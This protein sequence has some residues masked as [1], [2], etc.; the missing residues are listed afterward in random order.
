MEQQL[1][2]LFPLNVVL[3][4]RTPL[5][6]HIF[7]DRYKEMMADIIETKSEFGVVLAGEKGVVNT[8]CTAIVDKV[9]NKYEDG[10]MDILAVGRRRFEILLLNADK[11]YLRGA[12][13]F[14]DDDAFEPTP[15][16]LKDRVL[17]GYGDLCKI[18]PPEDEVSPEMTDP[19]LSFQ[20]AQILP[21][22]NFRQTLLATRSEAERMK[23][24]ADFLPTFNLR[25][26][27][28]AHVKSVAPQNGHGKRSP[29]L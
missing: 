3:F 15:D 20:L 1:L 26:R 18:E 12:V 13:E 22:L 11:S 23:R 7:E 4:P 25:Q 6:L 24:L 21:D 29:N 27:H 19:Q 14:F 16:A 17:E 9:L 2:P 28:I 8:G 5:P 10:R